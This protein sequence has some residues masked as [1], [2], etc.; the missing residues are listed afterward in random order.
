M[1]TT[2]MTQLADYFTSI[3]SGIEARESDAAL[4]Q[5]LAQT[6]AACEEAAAAQRT[7]QTRQ[8]L[9]NLQTALQ[10]WQQVWS[11]LGAQQEFRLAMAREARLWSKRLSDQQKR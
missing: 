10:T 9:T 8:L 3:V 2:P 5:T 7:P 1:T 6:A 4:L 11:R